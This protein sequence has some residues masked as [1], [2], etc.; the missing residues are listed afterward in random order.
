MSGAHIERPLMHLPHCSLH[1]YTHYLIL[2]GYCAW[3]RRCA[4]VCR[5]LM[6]SFAI[7][8]QFHDIHSDQSS[9]WCLLVV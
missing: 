7:D 9:V 5:V 6:V 3:F 1:V 8:N 4:E 2:N